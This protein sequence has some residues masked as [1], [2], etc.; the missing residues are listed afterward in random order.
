[1][2]AKGIM[3]K[4]KWL[5]ISWFSLWGGFPAAAGLAF[6]EGFDYAAG[7]LA[8]QTG[9]TGFSSAWDSGTVVADGLTYTDAHGK[10]LIVSGGAYGASAGTRF[11]DISDVLDG[12]A[13]RTYWLTY[14]LRPDA[15]GSSRWGG[16]S[17]FNHTSE[18]LF[19]GDITSGTVNPHRYRLQSYSPGSR[20]VTTSQNPPHWVVGQTDFIVVRLDLSSTADSDSIRLWVNPLLETAPDNDNALLSLTGCNVLATRIRMG[21]N[22]DVTMDEL[23]FGTSWGAVAPIPEPG[24]LL[25]LALTTGGALLW[26]RIR[27]GKGVSLHS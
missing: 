13:S 14:L 8:G 25:F 12:T 5:L 19:T 17:I 22:F 11:R 10:Q 20:T 21:H 9:G 24:T 4:S 16:L 15:T 1:M 26:R 6:Y 27:L 23:R 7:S 3:M 18:N 2:A